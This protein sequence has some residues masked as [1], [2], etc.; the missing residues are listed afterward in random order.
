MDGFT[1][2]LECFLDEPS[3]RDF[4]SGTRDFRDL[5]RKALTPEIQRR[6]IAYKERFP[7]ALEASDKCE[8]EA[9]GYFEDVLHP[10]DLKMLLNAVP[11][12]YEACQWP[13]YRARRRS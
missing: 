6:I 3:D 9:L 10:A 2:A 8:R 5:L 7:Q 12:Q 1:S 4:A 11:G 13:E